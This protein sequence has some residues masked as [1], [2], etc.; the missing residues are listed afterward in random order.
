MSDAPISPTASRDALDLKLCLRTDHDLPPLRR[1][2]SLALCRFFQESLSFL[3]H[4]TNA[5]ELIV[6]AQR[7]MG[8]FIL[9]LRACG[10]DLKSPWRLDVRS[11]PPLIL[12]HRARLMG[13]RSTAWG[14]RNE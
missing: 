4:E 11:E 3:P 1:V 13:G 10:N 8:Q 5:S 2:L 14:D 9:T 7:P 6:E 12:E